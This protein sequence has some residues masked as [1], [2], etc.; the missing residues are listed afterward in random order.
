MDKTILETVHESA[1]DLHEIGLVDA[2]T[3][4][5]FDSLA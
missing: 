2:I 3:M 1:K 4:R 5:E